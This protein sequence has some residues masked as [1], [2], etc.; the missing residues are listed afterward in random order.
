L[1][2]A[3]CAILVHADDNA[4][5]N[6][7]LCLVALGLLTLLTACT[8]AGSKGTEVTR[9]HLS[10]PIGPQPINIEAADNN[11][12]NSLAFSSYSNI[13]A[14]ELKKIGLEQVPGDSAKLVAIV[15]VTRNVQQPPPKR[16]AVSIG[17]GGGSYG[18]RGGIGAG[19]NVPVGA[20]NSDD[21][22]FV[23]TLDVKLIERESNTV[24]WEGNAMR[25]TPSGE[26]S[27]TAVV[28]QLAT[29]LFQDFPGKSGTTVT[30]N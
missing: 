15:G 2:L 11:S 18:S 23:T 3:E 19:V 10:K 1:N 30:V 14:A 9:F 22:V 24:T 29:A 25:T 17:V 12:P 5:N 28:Q 20:G 4:M 8:T 6:R 7:V 16:S 21:S 26:G 13:V 27:A